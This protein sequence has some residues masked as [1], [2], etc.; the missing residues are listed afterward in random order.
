MKICMLCLLLL[1]PITVAQPVGWR[2]DL[3]VTFTPT[4]TGTPETHN[5]PWIG[6]IYS[7]DF[8]I[9]NSGHPDPVSLIFDPS[10]F[11]LYG[12]ALDDQGI[13]NGGVIYALVGGVLYPGKQDGG[14]FG[15]IYPLVAPTVPEPTISVFLFFLIFVA[16]S[17]RTL[18]NRENADV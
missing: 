7:A 15:P 4:L 12:T 5:L 11:G 9:E 18:S 13:Q 14:G 16:I 6:S 1:S 2:T 3:D 10:S 17:G 8:S